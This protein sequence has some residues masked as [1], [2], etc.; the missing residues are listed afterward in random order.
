MKKN[1][2]VVNHDLQ[3]AS[4]DALFPKGKMLD[5]WELWPFLK[6]VLE[7][8]EQEAVYWIVKVGVVR[9]L[10]RPA[11]GQS[12]AQLVEQY[13]TEKRELLFFNQLDLG[14]HVSTPAKLAYYEEDGTLAEKEISDLG[15]LL[16]CS[17]PEKVEEKERYMSSDNPVTFSG[18]QRLDYE[19]GTFRGA[20][21]YIYLHTDIWFPKVMGY[22]EDWGEN[23]RG[24][25]IGWENRPWQDNRELALRHTPRLNRFLARVKQLTLEYGGAWGIDKYDTVGRYHSQ[26]NEDGIFLNTEE[27]ER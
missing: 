9:N 23:E 10:P 17:R 22:L 12:Y 18:A 14:Y 15:W 13:L 6:G 25:P 24:I 20:Y 5:P 19:D 26:W 21:L 3:F 2:W 11:E 8:G 27:E 1:I 7:I 4:W 16:R